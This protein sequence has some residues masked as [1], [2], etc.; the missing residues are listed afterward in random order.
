M[1]RIGSILR[2]TPILAL[3]VVV[4][5]GGIPNPRGA[6]ADELSNHLRDRGAGIPTSIFGT[7][8]DRGELLLFPFFAHSLDKNREYQP[9]M[10]HG[11]SSEDFRARYRDS[12]EQ[13]F[14]GY[15]L[16]D[17][18]ALEFETAYTKATFEK[19]PS[20][21]SGT[22][23]KIRESGFADIEGQL[24]F[25]LMSEGDR[26]PEVFGFLEIT[27]ASQRT[28]VLIGDSNWDFKPG[29][30]IVRGYSWGTM[31]FRT[32]GEYNRDNSHLDFGETS[33]EYLR[34]LSPAWRVNLALEGG[35]TGAPDE[36]ELVSGVQWRITD[37]VLLKLDNVFGLTS[38]ATDWSPQVGIMFSLH[39]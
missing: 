37:V 10:F 15:G 33:I 6:Q 14:I 13:I 29:L 34:R 8:I 24:R 32:T 16:N 5:V 36:W 4:G 28:K 35:E 21:T 9:V 31:T 30:G 18:L 1:G 25:R 22:P 17:W 23:A 26:H 11:G 12:G 7:Y 20:D 19:S 39:P 38:K 2:A 3:L 27:A